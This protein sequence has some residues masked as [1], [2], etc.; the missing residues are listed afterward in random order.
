VANIASLRKAAVMLTSLPQEEAVTML[1]K[2]D[3]RQ[4]QAVSAEIAALGTA[5]GE[6]QAAVI[7][8]FAAA[9]FG[10][11]SHGPMAVEKPFDFLQK[12]DSQKLLAFIIEEHPQTIALIV[13]HLPPAQGAGILAG[14]PSEQQLVVVRRIAAMKQI[15]P[16]MIHD[17]ENGLQDH[18]A[19]VMLVQF[20][21]WGGLRSV[22]EIFRALSQSVAV[23]LLNRLAQETPY[24]ADEIGRL[25]R[26]LDEPVAKSTIAPAVSQML[27]NYLPPQA[28]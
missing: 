27:R 13:S 24:L 17:V 6:E 23:G 14:L 22:A 18:L 3:P 15:D 4:A 11:A 16:E 2:L 9:S 19:S 8:E 5:S 7:N 28:A 10:T 20:Q 25:L 12:V 1:S 26:E 21:N